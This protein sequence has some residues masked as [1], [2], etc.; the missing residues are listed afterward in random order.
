MHARIAAFRLAA[1]PTRRAASRCSRA[2]AVATS[3]P[4]ATQ[5]GIAMLAKWRQR[6]RR[7]ARHRDHAHRRRALQQR[8]RLRPVRDPLGRQ[9]ARRP[10]RV[11]ARA[12]GVVARALRRPAQVD[13]ERGWDAVTIPGAVSGWVAL[14]QRYGKLP[15][16]DL[17]EPAIRYARD[18]FARVAD[19]RREMAARGAADA[20]GPRL[21]RALPAARPRAAGRRALRAA[22]R[23]PR[24]SK[25]SPRPT[26]TRSIAASS[27]RRWSR[28]AHAH[29]GV[30]IAR[31]FRRAH[32]P[33]G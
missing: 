21:R 11:G 15:F 2:N 29:G 14:S 16:A 33:T 10:Q 9:R 30:H 19:R 17:F 27:R 13:A 20:A 3:Q 25:R 4:L 6:R 22:R 8:H 26:A 23:W 24:R 18:G 1:C 12:G 7:G 32:A 28:Y 31:G 5:A